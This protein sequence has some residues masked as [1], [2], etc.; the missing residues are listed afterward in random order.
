MMHPRV[1]IRKEQ[2]NNQ[3]K[4]PLAQVSKQTWQQAVMNT[5][6]ILSRL[7]DT[8]MHPLSLLWKP[9]QDMTLTFLGLLQLIVGYATMSR[10]ILPT[11]PE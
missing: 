3:R 8:I 7:R 9:I 6:W 1:D 5:S 2:R 4:H 11:T 10:A